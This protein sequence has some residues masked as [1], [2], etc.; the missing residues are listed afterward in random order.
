MVFSTSLDNRFPVF[1]LGSTGTTERR[2][3]P[4]SRSAPLVRPGAPH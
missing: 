4:A 3:S 2:L 1:L